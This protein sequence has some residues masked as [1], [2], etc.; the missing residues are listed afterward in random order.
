MSI[1]QAKSTRSILS[2]ASLMPTEAVILIR[3]V[4]LEPD[5]SKE[6]LKDAIEEGEFLTPNANKIA[7]RLV[8]NI[9]KRLKYRAKQNSRN[10]NSWRH[11]NNW[12]PG[13]YIGQR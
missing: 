13:V 1:R 7:K 8:T 4:Y 11:V 3:S 9:N 5:K 10:K 12:W 6:Y 2:D